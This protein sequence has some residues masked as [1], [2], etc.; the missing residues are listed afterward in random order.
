VNVWEDLN[1]P[2]RTG[3]EEK[4]RINQGSPIIYSIL[5]NERPVRYSFGDRVK[6]SYDGNV[7]VQPPLGVLTK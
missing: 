5:Y 7:R 6:G 3:I 4:V 1:D 2:G